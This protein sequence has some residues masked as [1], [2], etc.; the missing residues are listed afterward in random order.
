MLNS[1]LQR[2]SVQEAVVGEDVGDGVGRLVGIDVGKGVGDGG[3]GKV[4]GKDVG[5]GVADV[6]GGV[7]DPSVC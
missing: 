5:G 2:I 7:R 1:S 4:V 3:V 6:G